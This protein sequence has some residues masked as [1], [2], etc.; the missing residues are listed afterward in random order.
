MAVLTTKPHISIHLHTMICF[1]C[2]SRSEAHDQ[3]KINNNNNNNN[4]NNKKIK[5][6]KIK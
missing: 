2:V 4:N 1:Q 5:K 3:K 6:Q